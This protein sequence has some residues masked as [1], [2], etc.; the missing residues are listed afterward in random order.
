MISNKKVQSILE[1]VD[2]TLID[3][4]LEK[5]YKYIK[6]LKNQFSAYFNL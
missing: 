5:F 1:R 4:K 2:S 6:D 3:D